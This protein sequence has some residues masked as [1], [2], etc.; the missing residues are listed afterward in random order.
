MKAQVKDDDEDDDEGRADKRGKRGEG[1][2]G[3][4]SEDTLGWDLGLQDLHDPYLLGR[5]STQKSH[6]STDIVCS[7][8]GGSTPFHSF[9]GRFF[10]RVKGDLNM[11]K[12]TT[13][14]QI[15]H[16]NDQFNDKTPP[17]L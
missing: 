13:K 8:G 12:L 14:R 1:E 9:W 2:G 4:T 16:H 5:P 17:C 11:T 10:S 7:G 6:T 15:L 3:V